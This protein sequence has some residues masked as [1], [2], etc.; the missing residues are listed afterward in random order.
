LNSLP[1]FELF[2][3]QV[4]NLPVDYAIVVLIGLHILVPTCSASGP[5]NLSFIYMKISCGRVVSLA[6]RLLCFPPNFWHLQWRRTGRIQFHPHFHGNMG[7]RGLVAPSSYPSS[8][9]LKILLRKIVVLFSK[10]F[11]GK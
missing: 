10:F 5:P 6:Q 11:L 4:L 2:G 7:A 9:P 3:G 8:Y 1:Q